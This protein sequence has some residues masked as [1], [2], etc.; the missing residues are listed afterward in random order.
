MD[1]RNRIQDEVF[2]IR[3]MSPAERSRWQQRIIREAEA[4]QAAAVGEMLVRAIAATFRGVRLLASSFREALVLRD[5]LPSAGQQHFH[6]LAGQSL[7]NRRGEPA[8][9]SRKGTTMLIAVTRIRRLYPGFFSAAV[10]RAFRIGYAAQR[11]WRL[12]RKA[13]AELHTFNDYALRDLGVSRSQIDQRVRFPA[14]AR[15][16]SRS[17]TEFI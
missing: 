14:R 13:A 8:V 1:A 11:R 17:A 9:A 10:L 6:G 3:L 4:A 5:A 16:L 15:M 7:Q 12:E 2:P